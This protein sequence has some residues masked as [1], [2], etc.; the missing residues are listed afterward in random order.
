MTQPAAGSL[1]EVLFGTIPHVIPGARGFRFLRRSRPGM[2][3]RPN[4]KNQDSN[5]HTLESGFSGDE[6]INGA[7]INDGAIG[8]INGVAT[9]DGAVDPALPS[10]TA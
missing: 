9:N 5:N 10:L 8:A 6:A 4:T 2:R 1:A 3:L 7:A